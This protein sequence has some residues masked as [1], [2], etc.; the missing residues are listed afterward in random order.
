MNRR[1]TDNAMVHLAIVLS[2]F[3]LF[4]T[5]GSFGH[6]IICLSSIHDLWFIWPYETQVMNRRK[7]DNAMAK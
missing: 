3:I 4:M 5:C 6:C 1:K 2:V 7:T